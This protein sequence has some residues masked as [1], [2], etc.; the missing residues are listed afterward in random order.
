MNKWKIGDTFV[1]T[2]RRG[3]YS[4]DLYGNECAEQC[5]G[6]F[7][8][9]AVRADKNKTMNALIADDRIFDRSLFRFEE[10]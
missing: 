8:V 4:R 10:P 7:V 9:T 5:L 1:A 6:R 3:Q 2:V